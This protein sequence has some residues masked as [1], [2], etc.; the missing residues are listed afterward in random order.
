MKIA[1]TDATLGSTSLN[2]IGNVFPTDAT[3]WAL[4]SRIR[5]PWWVVESARA[6]HNYAGFKIPSC[7]RVRP[8][9]PRRI[10]EE[11]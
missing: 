9:R 4:K 11:S 6:S 10:V 8:V 5:I 1:I 7:S 3:K 2:T